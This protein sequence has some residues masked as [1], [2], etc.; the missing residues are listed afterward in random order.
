[1]RFDWMNKL[2][3]YD[4]LSS[5]TGVVGSRTKRSYRMSSHYVYTT[6]A[7]QPTIMVQPPTPV[8]VHQP[9]P[10][11]VYHQ[12]PPQVVYHQPSPQVVYVQQQPQATVVQ[13]HTS[14]V[15][16]EDAA[17]LGCLACFG[18]LLCLS[19]ASEAARKN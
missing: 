14:E 12:P 2:A 4:W 16:D 17:C 1:M 18:A 7:P 19:A 13:T 5:M 9:P 3:L 11:V 10:Q 6:S 15:T 8:Y